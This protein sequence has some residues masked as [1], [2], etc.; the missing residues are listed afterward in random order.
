MQF[1]VRYWSSLL[2]RTP[3]EWDAPAGAELHW[4]DYSIHPASKLGLHNALLSVH[5]RLEIL[6]AHGGTYGCAVFVT[7]KGGV[8][9]LAQD[10]AD[11]LFATLP[12][13]EVK[14]QDIHHFLLPEAP[15]ENARP[16]PA[17]PPPSRAQLSLFP[18]TH[19]LYDDLEVVPHLLDIE[20]G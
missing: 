16:P 18:H 7:E 9:R 15:P 1:V 13:G 4:I 11:R 19:T 3:D 5:D 14:W 8:E 2:P 20:I 6:A 17:R 10:T 12:R